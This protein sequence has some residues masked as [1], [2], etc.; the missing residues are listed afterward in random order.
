MIVTY[1]Y[2][3][4]AIPYGFQHILMI[5]YIQLLIHFI[6]ACELVMHYDVDV[7]CI[8]IKHYNLKWLELLTYKTLIN[9]SSYN[10]KF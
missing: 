4:D 9:L 8:W 5:F 7:I 2:F 6:L 3:V 10:N 1:I